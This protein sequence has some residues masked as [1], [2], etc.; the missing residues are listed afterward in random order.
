MVVAA[1][2]GG[3]EHDDGMRQLREKL[4][5]S[6]VDSLRPALAVAV[7]RGLLRADVTAEAF[8][9]AAVGPMFHQRFLVGNPLDDDIV[10]AVLGTAW[11]AYAPTPAP[12]PHQRRGRA[13]T[14][15]GSPRKIQRR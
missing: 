3:A 11:Q 6:M 5:K 10:D 1:I 9:M 7:Q 13:D 2:I 4:V 8:A 14:Q 15:T 12:R